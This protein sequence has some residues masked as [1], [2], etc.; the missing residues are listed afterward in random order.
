MVPG[1]LI[2]TFF[3]GCVPPNVAGPWWSKGALANSILAKN[4]GQT[5][6]K[7]EDDT[8]RDNYLTSN[9]AKSYGLIDTILQKRKWKK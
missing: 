2:Y 1:P 7:I 3:A 8:D 4:T 6:K 5:I 9:Q